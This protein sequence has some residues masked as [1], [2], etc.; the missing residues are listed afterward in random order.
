MNSNTFGA[1]FTSTEYYSAETGEPLK[2]LTWWDWDAPYAGFLGAQNPLLSADQ[3]WFVIDKTDQEFD[4]PTQPFDFTYV[5]NDLQT[6][7]AHFLSQSEENV[8]DFVGWGS[9]STFYLVRRPLNDTIPAQ[10]DA[11]FGLLAF[12]P[13]NRQIRLVNGQIRYA[14]LAPDKNHILGAYREEDRLSIAIYT[15]DGQPVTPT[16]QNPL[17][18]VVTVPGLSKLQSIWEIPGEHGLL[19]WV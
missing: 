2:D 12:D 11:P 13:S 5:L 4:D 8:L 1:A 3:R 17:P 7:Q 14:W 15:P 9:V 18:E 16:I 6:M 10:P 19:N